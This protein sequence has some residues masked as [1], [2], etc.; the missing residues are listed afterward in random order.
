MGAD[1]AGIG[2]A[3]VKADAGAALPSP[4]ES[5]AQIKNPPVV[6]ARQAN[7]ASG[8]QQVN[9]GVTVSRPRKNEIPPSK[10]SGHEHELLP[11]G[12]ASA[13]ASGVD[14][15]L[16]AVGAINRTTNHRG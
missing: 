1:R 12:R 9:N 8:P 11:D 14:S 3:V 5:L 13:P 10:L 6:Y 4:I 16:E 7:F 2:A 15:T